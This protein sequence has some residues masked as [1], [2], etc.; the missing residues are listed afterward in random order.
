MSGSPRYLTASAPGLGCVVVSDVGDQLRCFKTPP[1]RGDQ[2]IVAHRRRRSIR[3]SGRSLGS[4][5]GEL[6]AQGNRALTPDVTSVA[7]L[8][9]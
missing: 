9:G 4:A 8:G 7:E 6:R 5:S 3:L 2:V 1:G